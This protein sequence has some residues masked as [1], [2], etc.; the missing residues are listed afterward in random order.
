MK[1]L[2]HLYNRYLFAGVILRRLRRC[3]TILEL[4]CGNGSIL[5]QVGLFKN[6][7]ITGIDIFKPYVDAMKPYYTKCIC[8]NISHIE[9]TEVFDAVVC[10]DVI[11]HLP[12]QEGIDLL[13]KMERWAK[14]IVVTTPNGFWHQDITD[15]NI[16]QAHLSGWTANELRERGYIVRGLSGWKL[17]RTNSAQLRFKR[18]YLFWALVSLLTIPVCYWL[19]RWSWHLLATKE[20]AH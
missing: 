5:F 16:H 20:V 4:G 7:Q 11:E 18:P 15:G 10:M 17:L 14:F 12:K 13:R 1:L 3:R 6:H 8:A 9:I 19:P 2:K